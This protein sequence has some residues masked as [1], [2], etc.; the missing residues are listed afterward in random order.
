MVTNTLSAP[1]IVSVSGLSKRFGG[2]CALEDVSLE[3]AA[4]D[5]VALLGP[6][7]AGK[8]TL[9]S[10]I[11]GVQKPDSGQIC[12]DGR[13]VVFRGA[14]DARARGIQTVYQDLALCGNLSASG[15]LFL[16]RELVRRLGPL[17]FVDRR[18]MDRFTQQ[19]LTELGV[20]LPGFREATEG[21]S[22]GQ[23]QALAFARS[24]LANARLLILDEPT[25]ALGVTER[26]RVLRTVRRLHEERGLAVLLVT[27]NIADMRELAT[28]IV[29]LRQ[30]RRV[31]DANAG[32]VD[33]DTVVGLITGS[34]QDFLK[35][36]GNGA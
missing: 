4:G 28:R 33:D 6:N 34:R 8:S 9:V 1:K 26:E 10:I 13:P 24:I 31:A 16:G 25:A 20:E 29:V 11:S 35:A 30:G 12:V 36:S 15:N 22:G 7:G 3:V 23:R 32:E 5:C 21:Y 19:E 2:V 14:A 17:R 18:A 27:H